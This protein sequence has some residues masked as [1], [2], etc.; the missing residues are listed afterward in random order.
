L[1]FSTFR[2]LQVFQTD[3][4][5]NVQ[6]A[7]AQSLEWVRDA[8]HAAE[9]REAHYSDLSYQQQ[10]GGEGSGAA[11]S[12][13]DGSVTRRSAEQVLLT[14]QHHAG[15]RVEVTHARFIVST[16]LQKVKKGPKLSAS[17]EKDGAS[18]NKAAQPLRTS[19]DGIASMG[20][21][22]NKQPPAT[23]VF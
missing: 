8:A 23:K 20:M 2:K 12:T 16:V 14:L 4:R 21:G 5:C 11:S 22:G 7:L 15:S 13:D 19:G 10:A 6:L 1:L 3:C 17:G 9:L 18:G